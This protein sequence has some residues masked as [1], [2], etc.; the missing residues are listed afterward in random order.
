MVDFTESIF[1]INKS[2]CRIMFFLAS[3]TDDIGESLWVLIITEDIVPK[4][5]LSVTFDVLI[6]SCEVV[7]S[8]SDDGYE[9]FRHSR[10]QRYCTEISEVGVG[11]F[12]VSEN[13]DSL[14]PG[15]GELGSG[16]RR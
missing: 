8:I 12:F 1:Q 5:L 2:D 7:K 3:I 15:F 14:F 13:G 10:V 11:A 6:F 9:D 16:P 4:Y